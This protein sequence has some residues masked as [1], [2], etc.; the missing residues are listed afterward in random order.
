MVNFWLTRPQERASPLKTLSENLS[1]SAPEIED[2]ATKSE[3]NFM[4]L[5]KK[6]INK[7]K[8]TVNSTLGSNSIFNLIYFTTL[9]IENE[10]RNAAKVLRTSKEEPQPLGQTV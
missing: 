5:E 7:R 9:D 1:A 10:N 8:Q 3:L 4:S 2:A 6:T